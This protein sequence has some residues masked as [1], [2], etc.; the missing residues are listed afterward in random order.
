MK[1]GWPLTLAAMLVAGCMTG[2][3]RANPGSVATANAGVPLTA[4]PRTRAE[5]TSYR[6]TSRY[7]DVITFLDSLRGRAA[8]AFGSL[9][10]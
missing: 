5:L 6:E 7:A 2:S 1:L 3:T 4:G 10:R 8:L 9:G